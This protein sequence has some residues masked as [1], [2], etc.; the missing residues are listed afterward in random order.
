MLGQFFPEHVN[1]QTGFT[2]TG[3]AADHD[4]LFFRDQQVQVFQVML[5][6]ETMW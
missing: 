4:Q 2:R 5:I 3:N 1:D 6:L